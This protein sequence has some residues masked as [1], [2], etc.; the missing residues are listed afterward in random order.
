MIIST[1]VC[2]FDLRS[3]SGKKN[4]IFDEEVR[5]TD[6]VI[7]SKEKEN[8]GWLE[9]NLNSNNDVS[10]LKYQNNKDRIL[11]SDYLTL[12][13]EN[14]IHPP[15]LKDDYKEGIIKESADLIYHM[16][17]LWISI[18]VNPED[19]LKELSLRK[20]KSG[21]EEKTLF[22]IYGSVHWF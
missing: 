14:Y 10:H 5:S 22:E 9:D 18:G 7:I 17:V 6:I 1:K 20:K 4:K 8:F 16:F 19:I 3:T 2:L 12:E 15:L 11:K 13:N 21:F